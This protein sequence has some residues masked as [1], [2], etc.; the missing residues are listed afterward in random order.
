MG[1]GD[2]PVDT[3]KSVLSK[4]WL[5][6]NQFIHKTIAATH[7]GRFLKKLTHQL[8]VSNGDNPLQARSLS[9]SIPIN[10]F[11]PCVDPVG[12]F[13]S[14]LSRALTQCHPLTFSKTHILVGNFAPIVTINTM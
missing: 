7:R 9:S 14:Q 3:L 10:G 8:I 1:R 5:Q 11:R 12:V 13:S 4:G 6:K 2:L